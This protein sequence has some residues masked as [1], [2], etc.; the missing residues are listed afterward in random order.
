MCKACLH[1][2][3]WH[4]Q[5]LLWPGV[6]YTPAEKQTKFM[7]DAGFLYDDAPMRAAKPRDMPKR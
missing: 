5:M 7:Q 4:F 2:D 1:A 6:D 3:S